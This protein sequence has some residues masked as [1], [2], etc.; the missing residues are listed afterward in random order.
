MMDLNQCEIVR[1]DYFASCEDV[2][3]TFNQGKMYVNNYCIRNYE[4]TEYIQVLVNR[5]KKMLVL[6]LLTEKKKDSIRWATQG[7]K[8]RA[9][10]IRCVP[11]FYLVVKMMKWDVDFRYRITGHEEKSNGQTILCFLLKDAQ[12]FVPVSTDQNGRTIYRKR[13]P[14]EW[15]MSFGI[16][17]KEY[18]EGE[19]VLRYAEDGV[20]EIE[21][22]IRKE[23]I[24]KI[25]STAENEV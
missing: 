20:Y 15:D 5:E 13:M 14:K 9:R 8:R 6:K 23:R 25:K 3:L 22:P 12:C 18:G 24:E 1:Q 16:S 19:F 7:E 10:H 11:L 17:Q 21:L 4:K 2:T